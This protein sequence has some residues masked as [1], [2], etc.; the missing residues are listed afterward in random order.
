M[1]GLLAAARFPS[2]LIKP[3][4]PI[5]SIRLSDRLHHQL[6]NGLARKDEV[7]QAPRTRLGP[8]TWPCLVAATNEERRIGVLSKESDK[9]RFNVGASRARDQMWLFHS[10]TPDDLSS[11]C[12]RRQLLGLGANHDSSLMPLTVRATKPERR[13]ETR[14]CA[15]VL[16]RPSSP[17]TRREKRRGPEGGIWPVCRLFWAR[18]S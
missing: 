8:G 14:R 15:T 7:L 9:R 3:D 16:P 11:L 13:R 17:V 6:M 12:L 5:S 10:V 4:V 18:G 2:P 1:R